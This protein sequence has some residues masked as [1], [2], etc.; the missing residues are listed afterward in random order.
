MKKLTTAPN[1]AECDLLKALLESNGIE[2]FIKNDILFRLAGGVPFPEVMPELWV[3]NDE[4]FGEASA[5]L[6][7]TTG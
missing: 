6:A 1:L 2:C 4:D 3:V 7:D 5:I